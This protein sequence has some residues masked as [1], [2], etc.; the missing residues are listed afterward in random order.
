[1]E[2]TIKAQE[3]VQHYSGK[4]LETMTLWADANQRMLRDFVEFSS[5]TAKEG[6]RLYTELQR[7]AIEAVR[8]SQA[9]A[10]RWQDSW[11]ES[12]SD[13]AA[14]YQKL[15]AEGV[16]NAQ[17]T[18]RFVEEN[19]QAFTRAAER[20]QATAEQTGKGVQEAFTEAVTKTKEIYSRS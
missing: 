19:A 7:A 11:K 17:K 12:S 13:P 14:W 5:G 4:A 2:E 6:V 16:N 1:M 10:L 20:L 15:L 3:L 18:F 9:T 8:D